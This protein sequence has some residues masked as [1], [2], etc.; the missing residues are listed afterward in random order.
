[1]ELE[2][3]IK[4]L[5]REQNKKTG[6]K[7]TE[8]QMGKFWSSMAVDSFKSKFG[9]GQIVNLLKKYGIDEALDIIEVSDL[10]R[11]DSL[12]EVEEEVRQRYSESVDYNF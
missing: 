3:L 12:F 8:E 2:K 6:V 4:Q 10:K 11:V 9:S 5:S 1:M 7:F